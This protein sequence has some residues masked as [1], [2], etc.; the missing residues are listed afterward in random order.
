MYLFPGFQEVRE[1]LISDFLSNVPDTFIQAYDR[2]VADFTQSNRYTNSSGKAANYTDNV[3]TSTR[4]GQFI[5]NSNYHRLDYVLTNRLMM[6]EPIRKFHSDAGTRSKNTDNRINDLSDPTTK[7]LVATHQPN[8]FSYGGVFKKI[9]LL[10]TMKELLLDLHDSVKIINLFL[11]IDHDFADENWIR[12]AQLPNIRSTDGIMQLRLP[13]NKS[14]RW[15][16]VCN[17]PLP[18]RTVLDY[19]KNQLFSWIRKSFLFQQDAKRV[20]VPLPYDKEKKINSLEKAKS[21]LISNLEI[22]WDLVEESYSNANSYSDFNSFLMSKI[23]NGLWQYDTL[24][25]KLTDLTKVF[26]RG[27]GNL[28]RNYD[29][30]SGILREAEQVFLKKRIPSGVSSSSYLQSPLWLHCKCGSKSASRITNRQSHKE[31]VE[32]VLEGNCMGCKKYLKADLLVDRGGEIISPDPHTVTELSPRS[33]PIVL[34][35]CSELGI[36]SYA[37]GTDGMRYIMFGSKLFKQ[38]SPNNI[39]LFMLWPSRDTYHGFA[40][41]EAL[42]SVQQRNSNDLEENLKRLK[43]KEEAYR[44]LIEPVL[45]KRNRRLNQSQSEKEEILA[46]LFSLKKDQRNTRSQYKLARKTKNTLNLRPCIIDYA[47]NFGLCN[48]ETQWRQ[49]LLFNRDLSCSN[50]LSTKFN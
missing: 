31:G 19:W 21:T 17:M 4:F 47:V 41:S 10:Q 37:S 29:I 33:I 50:E 16:M 43:E 5:F 6:I 27:Y 25:V 1:P 38:F 28:L 8:L 18:N 11:I 32:L 42:S 30:Y 40:Q 20:S 24:F 35:L 36:S 46:V 7:I 2:L 49:N 48:T 3:T 39:P 9:V 13:V 14:M 23:V 15:H 44:S 12:V 45:Q 26:R 22:F 34:L